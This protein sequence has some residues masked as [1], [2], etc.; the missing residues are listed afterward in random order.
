MS[1]RYVLES[2]IIRELLEEN[3]RL[4]NELSYIKEAINTLKTHYKLQRKRG[5]VLFEH[6]L[7]GLEDLEAQIKLIRLREEGGE[8]E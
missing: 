6:R 7:N 4:D 2:A 1:E 8:C 3:R 5:I